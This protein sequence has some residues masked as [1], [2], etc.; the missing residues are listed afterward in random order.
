MACDEPINFG[1]FRNVGIEQIKRDTADLSKPGPANNF[2]TANVNRYGKPGAIFFDDG[3]KGEFGI[4]KIVVC[5]LLPAF[6]INM[7]TKESVAIK[8]PDCRQRKIQIACRLQMVARKDTKSAGV[9]GQG[10][11]N[12]VFRA[13]VSDLRRRREWC[14]FVGRHRKIGRLTSRELIQPLH[15]RGIASSK[16]EPKTLDI[17]KENPRP[18]LAFIPKTRIEVAKQCDAFGLPRPI[19]IHRDLE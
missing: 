9:D 8:K 16:P 18:L 11:M 17:L 7:L 10:I 4:E 13:E 12:A 6:V 19:K 15:I 3:R 14:S 5:F 1:I 2:T